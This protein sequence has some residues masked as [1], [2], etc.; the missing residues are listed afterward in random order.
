[1]F[2]ILSLDGGGIKGVFTAAVLATL[3]EQT[4]CKAVDHFDLIA[5][6]STGGILAIGLGLGV[7]AKDL[8]A[9]YVERGPVI[10]PSTGMQGRF[11]LFRQ[12]FG[13]K[14][15]HATLSR[16]LNAVLGSRKFGE[17]RC[18]LIIPTYDAIAGRID[19]MKTAHDPRFVHD[20]EASAREV[21]LA[22]SAAPT[23]FAAAP[24]PR[25]LGAS[26]VDGGVWANCPALVGVVEAIAFLGAA[27]DG[28]D[29][30]SIGTTSAAF[31]I[32]KNGR[33]GLL[34]WNKGLLDLMSEAQAE[35][36]R[37][38]AG[39]L[40]RGRLHR[41]DFQAMAGQFSLDN[42][43]REAIAGLA[44]AGHAEATK[45]EHL[46]GAVKPR[47]LNGQAAPVFVPHVMV[48]PAP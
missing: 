30:L 28:I 34:R 46:E 41:I 36:A 2:R 10:F 32:S 8:L 23:Y 26:Y 9:F 11:G 7:P 3:E 17:S 42:A 12:L 25:H 45:K 35:A 15:S 6:T 39:L 43:S 4:G 1:M 44:A 47:F 22:T 29:V 5:G 33:S 14:H 27:P 31:N 20:I 19:V 24:F 48:D 37:A 21:A 13:P 40:A 16:E 38:Q 18:R